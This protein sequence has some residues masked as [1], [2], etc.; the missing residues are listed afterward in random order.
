MHYNIPKAYGNAVLTPLNTKHDK[1]FKFNTSLTLEF[2]FVCFSPH[3]YPLAKA[4]IN[5]YL[6]FF[7]ATGGIRGQKSMLILFERSHRCGVN[8]F[9]GM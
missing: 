3:I 8:A 4:Y 5:L 6:L 2:L 7:K 1:I 9:Y